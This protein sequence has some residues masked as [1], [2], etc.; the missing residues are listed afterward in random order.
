MSKKSIE[1]FYSKIRLQLEH[2]RPVG[3]FQPEKTGLPFEQLHF[4]Q[5][6]KPKNVFLLTP[7]RNFRNFC[8]NG[9]RSI[10][11]HSHFPYSTFSTLLNFHTPYFP[12]FLFATLLLFRTSY[13]PHSSFS[14]LLIFHSEKK[15]KTLPYVAWRCKLF[16]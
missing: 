3:T 8:S 4:F 15:S 12:F 13:F 10:L 14:I 2:E 9:K 11:P 1:T 16:Y 7:N 6:G 5:S